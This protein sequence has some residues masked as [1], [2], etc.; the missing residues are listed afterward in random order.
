MRL[1]ELIDVRLGDVLLRIVRV[2]NDRT[3]LGTLIG[4]LA[5][6]LGGVEHDREC[7]LQYLTVG[8][9]AGS[10]VIL[11]DSAWPVTPELTC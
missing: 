7:D 8:N 6:E 11:T 10:K 9:R 4:S 1:I 3:V 2:E 5:V